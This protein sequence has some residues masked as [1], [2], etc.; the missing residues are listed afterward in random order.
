MYNEVMK[1]Q[2]SNLPQSYTETELSTLDKEELIRIVLAN[3]ENIASMDQKLQKILEEIA[4]ANRNRFG[5][6]SEKIPV[7]NQIA[8]AEVN[9]EIVFFNEAE[10]VVDLSASE[11]DSSEDGIS[12]KNHTSKRLGKR[13]EGISGIPVTSI[14]HYMSDEELTSRFGTNGWKRL[15]DEV[16]KRYK[17]VPSSVGIEEHHVGVYASKKD[18]EIVKAKHPAYLLRG[19]LVSPS[20]EAAVLN[21]KYVNA[22]PLYRLEKEFERYGLHIPRQNMAKWTIECAERYLSVFYE[23]LKKKMLRYHVLQAD[24]TPLLVNKDGR[25]A[26]SKS[27][28]W[29]YRTCHMYDKQIILYEYQKTRNTSHPREF[30]KDFNGVCVTD[31]YQVYHTLEKEKEDLTI[32]GCWAHAR[33]RFDEAV[34]ALPKNQQKSCLANKALALIQGIYRADKELADLTPD[35]RRL[36]RQISVQPLVKAY[37]GFL[38]DNK[39]LVL[40]KSKTAKGFEYSLNQ[41]KYLETF[42]SD[43]EVP[44]DNNSAEQ[45]IRPFCIGKK[46]W[47]MIDTISGAKASAIAYSLAET[48]KANNLK[49]YDYFKYLLEVIPEHMEDTNLDFCENLLP[50]SKNLP[51]EIRKVVK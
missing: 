14:E 42:I 38:S 34:K 24:E 37:F 27:Y 11:D 43:G 46:N 33:R 29:V 17:F 6:S 26:G 28:M 4:C 12:T 41:Q 45:S 50:W 16:Y 44:M 31:G 21:A 7:A 35:E 36:K 1:N 32:A 25:D 48:A 8:F 9:G 18:D 51:D 40:P 22:T 49:P 5:R 20:L 15:P 39:H 23:Y 10:A 3:Q 13:E 30:L 2:T 19:S 47:V